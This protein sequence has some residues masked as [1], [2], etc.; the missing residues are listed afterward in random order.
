MPLLTS[1]YT[2]NLDKL[3]YMEKPK[4]RSK[5]EPYRQFLLDLLRWKF[6]S[7]DLYNAWA[8][9]MFQWVVRVRWMSLFKFVFVQS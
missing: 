2:A 7:P 8:E 9:G 3:H 4:L 1:W 6:V 5:V